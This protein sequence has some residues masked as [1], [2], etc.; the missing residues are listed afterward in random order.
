MGPWWER[1]ATG[2]W[3][4]CGRQLSAPPQAVPRALVWTDVDQVQVWG[5]DGCPECTPAPCAGLWVQGCSIPH[6]HT[7]VAAPAAARPQA[8]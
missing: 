1:W 7:A 5:V 8:P 3:E 4:P 2:R 6:S